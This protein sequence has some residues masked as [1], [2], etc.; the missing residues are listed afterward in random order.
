M[1]T[2]KQFAEIMG[3]ESITGTPNLTEMFGGPGAN[4]FAASRLK[5]HSLWPAN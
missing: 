1:A 2:A 3:C 5:E 4:G